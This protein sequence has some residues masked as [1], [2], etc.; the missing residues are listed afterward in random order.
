MT[1]KKSWPQQQQGLGSSG[2]GVIS[3]GR[4]WG[5]FG[6]CLSRGWRSPAYVTSVPGA[7]APTLTGNHHLVWRFLWCVIQCMSGVWSPR[8]RGLWNPH[9]Y[10]WRFML[11]SAHSDLLTLLVIVTWAKPL[12]YVFVGP[13]IAHLTDILDLLK[14]DVCVCLQYEQYVSEWLMYAHLFWSICEL[15]Y[16]VGMIQKWPSMNMN[17][18]M[19]HRFLGGQRAC[20]VDT[21]IQTR[22]FRFML[23]FP[24]LNC[25]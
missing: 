15:S 21:I 13:L 16:T 19:Y 22:W 10:K 25:V 7:P 4:G 17:R 23:T 12:I 6:A 5:S 11:T 24:D 1:R 20:T 14:Q 2:W 18:N 3:A 9:S 8:G